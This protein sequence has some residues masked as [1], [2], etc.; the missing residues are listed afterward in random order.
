VENLWEDEK[1]LI[2]NLGRLCNAHFNVEVFAEGYVDLEDKE[3]LDQAKTAVVLWDLNF[4]RSTLKSIDVTFQY[5][6]KAFLNSTSDLKMLKRI[7]TLS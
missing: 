5:A 7:F 1:L 2:T 4:G 6:V 3:G